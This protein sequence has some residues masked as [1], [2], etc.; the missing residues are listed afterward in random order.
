MSCIQRKIIKPKVG[1]LELAK[2]LGYIGQACNVMGYSRDN[3]YGF[4]EHYDQGGEQ[5][6]MDFSRRKP[7]MKNRVPESVEKTVIEPAIVY[8]AL[9]QERAS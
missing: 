8:P 5:T 6:L 1:L 9:G 7:V 2:R 4:K 3:F